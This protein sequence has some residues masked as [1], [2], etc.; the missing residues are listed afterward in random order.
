M[1]LLSC[2]LSVLCEMLQLTVI[3]TP[4]AVM[5]PNGDVWRVTPAGDRGATGHESCS[6]AR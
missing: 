6:T 4:V 3:A 1:G 2:L 5:F